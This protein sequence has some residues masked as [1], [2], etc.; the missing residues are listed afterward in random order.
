MT[1]KVKV[2]KALTEDLE[3]VNELTDSMHRH[4][5]GLYGLE[6][7]ELELEEEHFDEEELGNVYVADS[8]RDGVIGYMSFSKGRDEWAGSHYELEHIVVHENF[9]GHGVG[10]MLFEIL[11]GRAKLEGVNITTGTLARNERAL[12]F[13]EELGFRQIST[14]LLLDLQKRILNK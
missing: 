1:V 6:L 2:R 5:A 7:S 13:Y 11:L 3:A 14:V 9:R 12:R 4:L 8:V 10:K